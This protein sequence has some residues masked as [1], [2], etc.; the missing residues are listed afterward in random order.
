MVD[1]V[2]G[3]EIRQFEDRDLAGYNGSYSYTGFAG[4]TKLTT[5]AGLNV[6]LDKTHNSGLS[7]T[8]D[9]YT[10][11]NQIKLG[12]ITELSLSPYISETFAFN[13]HFSINAGLRFD[14]FYHKYN[15]KLASDTTLPG[16][17]IYKAQ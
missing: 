2:N 7:H 9:R 15:N 16:I 11:L 6:R 14:Q 5:E 3:D 17:G 4:N 12:D 13:E 8:V 1:T 10:T